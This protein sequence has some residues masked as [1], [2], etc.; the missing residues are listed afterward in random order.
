MFVDDILV[1]N[2]NRVKGGG[3]PS[4]VENGSVNRGPQVEK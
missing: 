2:E 1:R 3:E 4:E